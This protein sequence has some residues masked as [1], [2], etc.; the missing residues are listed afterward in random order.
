MAL[1]GVSSKSISGFDPRSVIPGCSLW[2][3]A[4]D[5]STLTLSG[6]NVIQWNDKSG[7]GNHALN[8]NTTVTYSSNSVTIAAG[9]SLSISKLVSSLVNTPFVYFVVEQNY[10]NLGS[11]LTDNSGQ[12]GSTN[13]LLAMVLTLSIRVFKSCVT[14]LTLSICDCASELNDPM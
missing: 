6:S 1:V 4:A 9:S 8:G 11:F 13:A 14:R 12:P 5:S 3:D 7:N 2:L 10:T